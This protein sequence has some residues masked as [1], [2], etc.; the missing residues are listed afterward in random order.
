MLVVANA[1][2]INRTR[3]LVPE[4]DFF[5]HLQRTIKLL[6]NLSPVSPVFKTNMEVLRKAQMRVNKKYYEL[7]GVFPEWENSPRPSNV[8]MTAPGTPQYYE[9]PVSATTSFSA[10]R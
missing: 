10:P 6:H 1:Y 2:M 7:N 4:R 5:H 8:P 3:P 9:A